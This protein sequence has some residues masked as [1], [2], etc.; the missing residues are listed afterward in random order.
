[1]TMEQHRPLLFV[2]AGFFLTPGGAEAQTHPVPQGLPYSQDFSG[3][4]H[5]SSTFPDGWQGWTIPDSINASY[6][7]APPMGNS[8]LRASSTAGTTTAAV[9]NYNGKVGI[10]TG[11]DANRCIVLAVNT[12]GFTNVQVAYDAMTIRIPTNASSRGVGLQ[13]RIGT[14]GAFTPLTTTDEDLN[15]EYR[16][17]MSPVTTSGTT[18]V[19]PEAR[20]VALPPEC[21]GQSVVQLRW[22]MRQAVSVTSAPSFAIDN[23]SVT[24]TPSDVGIDGPL[25]Q[26]AAVRWL[27]QDADGGHVVEVRGAMVT[28]YEVLDAM[29][30][31]TGIASNGPSAT[32]ERLRIG[33]SGQGTG[34][35]LLRLL[36]DRGPATVRLVHTA[37]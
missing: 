13:Y 25:A 32:T 5:N 17:H 33:L 24:G 2:L 19:G 28:G 22:T 11:I 6:N 20:T 27:G 36:T 29:G 18:P 3:L 31:L 1:M 35:Y 9:Q 16:T 30:R 8:N 12:T 14:T 21:E 7:T 26:G 4:A 34:P 15:N 10:Y 37:H 23:V